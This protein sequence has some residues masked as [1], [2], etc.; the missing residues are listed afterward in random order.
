MF[1]MTK[2]SKASSKLSQYIRPR[3]GQDQQPQKNDEA[4]DAVQ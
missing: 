1:K 2:F 3:K 4:I